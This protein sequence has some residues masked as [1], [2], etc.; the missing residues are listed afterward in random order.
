[1]VWI[2]HS[3]VRS[4]LAYLPS[5]G[6]CL[7][8]ITGLRSTDSPHSSAFAVSLVLLFLLLHIALLFCLGFPTEAFWRCEYYGVWHYP[9]VFVLISFF[10]VVFGAHPWCA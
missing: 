6:A 9:G 4:Y 8:C 7:R 10:F 2:L 5:S 1:M 3:K